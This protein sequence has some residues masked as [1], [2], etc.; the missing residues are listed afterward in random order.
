MRDTTPEAQEAVR[1]ATVRTAPVQRLRD[2]LAF[3]ETMREL[4]LA[5]L[6]A[7][8]PDRSTLELVEIL[9]NQQLVPP[10]LRASH[11]A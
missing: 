2:A 1:I 11:R 5:R 4:S 7:R 6:R 9:L 10:N 3:S 8:H